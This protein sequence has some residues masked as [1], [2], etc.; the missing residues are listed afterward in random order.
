MK[1]SKGHPEP[2][3][4]RILPSR[5]SAAEV[6]AAWPAHSAAQQHAGAGSITGI[7]L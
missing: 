2:R 5:R 4:E 1:R 6:A 3:I 7:G